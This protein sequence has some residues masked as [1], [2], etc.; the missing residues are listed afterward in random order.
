[1]KWKECAF[2][3]AGGRPLPLPLALSS[4]DP[5]LPRPNL[6]S[7]PSLF[8]MPCSNWKAYERE[9]AGEWPAEA[10]PL[11]VPEALDLDFSLPARSLVM[12]AQAWGLGHPFFV[13]KEAGTSFVATVAVVFDGSRHV[14]VTTGDGN[15]T[16][17]LRA[18]ACVCVV[19]FGRS[20]GFG[21]GRVCEHAHHPHTITL[22]LAQWKPRRRKP[23]GMATASLCPRRSR[24]RRQP[25]A[26]PRWPPLS[27]FSPTPWCSRSTARPSRSRPR[28]KRSQPPVDV[29][30]N[31]PGRQS[32]VPTWQLFVAEKKNSNKI[33][34]FFKKNSRNQKEGILTRDTTKNDSKTKLARN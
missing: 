5:P 30:S 10:V 33:I 3:G 28:A 9:D 23:N 21:F 22:T 19:S 7:P 6:F 25:R 27:S 31:N 14:D 11:V 13:I 26:P 32:G 1:M 16:L 17:C 20:N 8:V 18:R 34:R 12:L 4:S 15:R 24:R 29:V 2:C